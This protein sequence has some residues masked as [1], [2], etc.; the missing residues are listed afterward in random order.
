MEIPKLSV[1]MLLPDGYESRRRAISFLEK[2]TVR[3]QIELVLVTSANLVFQLDEKQL[4]SFGSHQLLRVAELT[5]PGQGFAA[6]IRGARA[7]VVAYVEEHSFPEPNWAQALLSAHEGPY[8]AVGCSISNA[9]PDTLC[10]WANLFEEFGPIVAPAA[11]GV[12]TYLGGHHTSYKRDLLLTY[13]DALP[14]LLDNETA[15]H[16]DLRRR[17]HQ[18]YLAGD[19][20][21]NHVNI[22]QLRAYMRQ[23]FVGQRSFAATRATA[24][25]WSLAKRALYCLASP[26][27]PL[28]RLFRILKE[29]RRARRAAQLLPQILFLLIPA[30]ACGTIGETIGYIFGDSPSNIKL[31]AEAE[32]DRFRFLSPKEQ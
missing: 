26:L 21:S 11:S 6:G 9:N 28:V 5:D 29:M 24:Q 23:D 31:K 18:L 1:V 25:N 12:A 3:E 4:E 8:A 14:N 20:V 17:G 27:I 19:A 2:Q 30:I 13:G 15:L 32:L 16:I 10:S 22:S 7:P